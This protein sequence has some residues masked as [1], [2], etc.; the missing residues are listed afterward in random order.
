MKTFR[1]LILLLLLSGAASAQVDDIK[2]ESA[3]ASRS[4]AS[5][6]NASSNDRCFLC[7]LIFF[8]PDWQKY[9]LHPDNKQRYPSMVSLETMLPGG[10]KTDTYFLW[11]RV[12]GNWGLFSTDFRMNYIFEKDDAGGYKQLHT[13]DWQV[14]Q[15]NITTSRFLL[16]RV[17]A[18]VM[19][20]AFGDFNQYSEV[21]VG[22]G[23]HAPD[24]T[25]MFYAEYRDAFKSGVDVK[26]RIEFNAQYMHQIFRAGALKGYLTGG[27]VYQKYYSQ[28]DFW[29]VQAGLAFRVFSD[30]ERY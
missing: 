22:F 29:A 6:D 26:A 8:I 21:T 17:G 11:P 28:I 20:E 16:F 1:W 2:Q 13:N 9:K 4:S 7:N 10:Y 25:N 24:Q 23:I 27:V 15:L 5:A 30:S 3:K 14:I 12:R 19:T 18:G